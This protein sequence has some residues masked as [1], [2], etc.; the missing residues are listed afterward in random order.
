MSAR[1]LP[2][3]LGASSGSPQVDNFSARVYGRNFRHPIVQ[4]RIHLLQPIPPPNSIPVSSIEAPERTTRISEGQQLTLT[5]EGVEGD[6]DGGL[7]RCGGGVGETVGVLSDVIKCDTGRPRPSPRFLVSSIQAPILHLIQPR[8]QNPRRPSRN[9]HPSRTAPSRDAACISCDASQL[10]AQSY[11][12]PGWPAQSH[13]T[14][15]TQPA[16][17]LISIHL[18]FRMIS[19]LSP[20]RLSATDSRATC[21][22]TCWP[23]PTSH[24]L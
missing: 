13:P 16:Q 14:R 11:P 8:S 4:H 20:Q 9:T 7:N 3:C 21:G 19:E 15:R 2:L 6:G 24:E 17:M 1:P 23:S 22:P 12:R 5:L 10:G 18:S